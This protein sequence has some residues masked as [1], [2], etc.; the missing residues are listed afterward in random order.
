VLQD[1]WNGDKALEIMR[2]E[3]TSFTMAS[4]PFLLDLADSVERT[5]TSLP[6]FR[7]F[8]AGGAPIPSAL[9]R[10]A[11]K[12]LDASIVSIWGMTECGAS[13]AT[14]VGDPVDRASE[15]DGKPNPGAEIKIVDNVGRE[16]PP[17]AEGNLQVRSSGNFVGYLKRPQ[18][19]A[20]DSDGWLDTGDLATINQEG[21]VRIT[22]RTKDVIIRGG[23]NIPVVEIER[24]LFEHPAVAEAAIVPYPDQRLG[25]RACA[26]IVLREGRELSLPEMV[27]FLISKQCAKNYLPE[28][29][30]IVNEMPRTPSGKIQ[31]YVL[32]DQAKHVAPT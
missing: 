22:G 5:S 18:W 11:S 25:E 28:R 6:D 10:R 16:L 20:T 21:Y 19:Y 7:V 8:V 30:K 15:T 9:V 17:G 31:K 24:L 12:L 23:E 32:R 1:I 29:L 13:T 14:D 4:T 3:R 26:F 2:R 27:E